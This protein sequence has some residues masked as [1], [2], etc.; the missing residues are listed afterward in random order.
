MSEHL[1]SHKFKY[2]IIRR[3]L[4]RLIHPALLI[5]LM[6]ISMRGQQQCRLSFQQLLD[7]VCAIS[8]SE[9]IRKYTVN[10]PFIMAGMLAHQIG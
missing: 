10:V 5:L 2:S 8:I 6:R 4:H 3:L 7:A 1:H 9:S